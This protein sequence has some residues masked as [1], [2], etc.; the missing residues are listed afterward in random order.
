[1]SLFVASINSGSNGNCYYIGHHDAAVLV[2]AGISCRETEKRLKRLGLSIRK[3]KAIF[4][5]H[6]HADH[7]H[8]VTTLSKKYKLPV[9]ISEITLRNSSV[10]LKPEHSFHFEA[11]RKIELEG[12]TITPIP[13]Q[14]DAADPYSFVVEHQDVVVGVFTDLGKPCDHTIRQFSACHAAFLETNYDKEML[15]NGGY[16]IHLKNRIKSDFGHLSNAQALQLFQQHRSPQLSHLFL[17][18]LS[19]ENN[20]PKLV[21]EAFE[22]HAGDTQII[23]ASRERESKLYHIRKSIVP[24]NR[25]HS[26]REEAQLSL[27]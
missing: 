18:H 11:Y 27:F 23:V 7:I 8:G 24:K 3:V 26:T 17:A 1:M 9:Y 15:D 25:V 19:R 4:I 10:E 6:E 14:H 20:R 13:K 22:P 5:T 16:P 21:K 12:I 2:D